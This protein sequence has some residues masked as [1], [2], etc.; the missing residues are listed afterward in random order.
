VSRGARVVILEKRSHIGGNAYSF[1]DPESGVEVHKYGSHLFQTSNARMWS[2][3]IV[4]PHSVSIDT[5]S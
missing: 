3:L 4:P 5:R 1:T 2:R